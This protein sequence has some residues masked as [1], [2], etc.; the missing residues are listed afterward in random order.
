[1][2]RSSAL[3]LAISALIR[4]TSLGDMA[5]MAATADDAGPIFGA[6]WAVLALWKLL[7]VICR[8]SSSLK[9]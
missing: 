5:A 3:S 4:C 8:S 1:M 6:V 7:I 9:P 2:R